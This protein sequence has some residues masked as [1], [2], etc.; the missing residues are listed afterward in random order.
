MPERIGLEAAL[1]MSGWNK[2]VDRYNKDIGNMQ[3]KTGGLGTKMSGLGKSIIGMG[4]KAALV[5]GAGIAAL[6]A[7]LAVIATK[8]IGAAISI[9]SAFT[10][11]TKTT[12][13]LRDEFGKLNAEGQTMKD[14]FLALSEQI[15]ISPEQLMSIG[16]MGGQLGVQKDNLLDFTRVI[17]DMGETTNLT[18]DAA[19]TDLARFAEVM[20]TVEEQGSD[21]WSRMGSAIVAL[22][23][24]SATTE[25]DILSFGQRIA[26][27]G[28]IVGLTEADVLAIGAAFSSVGVQAEAGGTAVQKMLL[29]MNKAVIEGG[30]EL[31]TFAETAGL[32]TEEFATLFE[33]DAAGAFTLFVE[34][35]GVAGDDAINILA[36]LGME[37]QRLVRGFL[38]L[39]G[40][41]ELLR[42][43]MVT[44]NEAFEENTA[45]TAE[46]DQRY[47][48][49]AAQVEIMK[50]TLRNLSA[51]IGDALLPIFNELLKGFTKFVQDNGP[52]ITAVFAKI[53]E[54]IGVNL[55]IAVAYLSQL[56]TGTLYPA[57]QQ[58]IGFIQANVIPILQQVAMWLGE[59]LPKA[60]AFI[61]EHWEAFRAALVA[62][63]AVLAVIGIVATIAAIAAAL[64]AL[65]NPI[66]LIIV[67]I[68]LLAAAWT[69]DWGGIRT[70]LEPFVEDVIQWFKTDLPVAIDTLATAWTEIV[71]GITTALDDAGVAVEKFV[72]GVIG[73]FKTLYDK[74]VGHS[75][76]TDLV[77]GIIK[78]FSGLPGKIIGALADLTFGSIIK[79]LEKGLVGAV[80]KVSKIF[81]DKIG[82]WQTETT[83]WMDLLADITEETLPDLRDMFETVSTYILE[84]L[85][86]MIRVTEEWQ[87]AIDYIINVTLPALQAMFAQVAAA[88]IKNLNDMT[89]AANEFRQ[90]LEKI[91]RLL[92]EF[93]R[94][95]VEAFRAVA[96]EVKALTETISGDGGLLDAIED[97]VKAV[98]NMRQDMVSDI[99][100]VIRAVKE[101]IGWLK[102]ALYW[103]ERVEKGGPPAMVDLA[104]SINS[105]ATAAGLLAGNLQG[106]SMAMPTVA[107]PQ[108]S[109]PAMA[110]ATTTNNNV[111]L[112]FGPTTIN[113]GLDQAL[114]EGRVRQ[115]VRDAMRGN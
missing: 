24:T 88:I 87:A 110:G 57:L 91:I 45:L 10:G 112:H 109:L 70:T 92:P 85:A 78:L 72:L 76:I 50:N 54:W 19:A 22:G 14:G 97:A 30:K 74:L 53:A 46:A 1:E 4:A 90:A 82:K 106:A 98:D 7:G 52:A 108:M 20:N 31:E 111:N 115:T 43:S 64:T 101:L 55:P 42:D 63:G 16:E 34:G 40:A 35:L 83:A 48:D 107:M 33:D 67:A 113:S 28:E 68:G 79:A 11:V 37:D 26:G 114:F 8:G 77:G 2:N 94:A 59:N 56:W 61:N 58:T 75:I 96:A 65:L 12:E 17:A 69:E 105:V 99:N 9:E 93:K 95:G 60:L 66:T 36:E 49:T 27:V 29:G 21:A 13:G 32:T 18:T 44:S 23:N 51:T 6:G 103:K 39:S 89:E 100:S 15:P 86:E 25:S 84:Q 47:A 41:G 38:A 71:T 104:R 81:L 3:R 5:A 73:W 62:I 80:D 102:S